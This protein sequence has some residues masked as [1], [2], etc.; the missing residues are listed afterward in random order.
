[1]AAI[2]RLYPLRAPPFKSLSVNICLSAVDV[3][4]QID[5]KHFYLAVVMWYFLEPNSYKTPVK[6]HENSSKSWLEAKVLV[7]EATLCSV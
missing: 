4:V 5:R 1:M 3:R 6:T 7:K 2:F